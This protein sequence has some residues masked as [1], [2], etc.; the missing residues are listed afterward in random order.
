MVNKL[1][2]GLVSVLGVAFLVCFNACKSNSQDDT[3][4]PIIEQLQKTKGKGILF[5]HQD[6][7]AYGVEWKY[8]SGE[9]DVKRVA[10]DY[11]ALFGWEL[12][13]IELGHDKN[14]DTVPFDAIRNFAIWAHEHG[15]INT[16]SW[17][18]YSPINGVNSW[19]GDSIVV[20][21]ILPGG[22]YHTQFNHQ[23][24]YVADFFLQFK[25]AGGNAIPFIFR[26][27]HEMDGTWFWWG[28]KTCTAKEF[29]ILF[30]YTI[31]YLH[32]KGVENMI[33]AYSPDCKFNT[34]EEYLKWY[35]GDDIISILGMDNYFDFKQPKGEKEALR[36][37]K[38][39]IELSN[40]RGKFSALSETGSENAHDTTFYTKK[41]GA[42]LNDTTVKANL[43][44]V[45]IW[46]NA[47]EQFFFVCPGTP[48]ANDA[49]ELLD[50]PDIL[51]LNEFVKITK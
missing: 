37:L 19:H 17:H 39:V 38:L 12:G 10:E 41:I 1:K 27:W 23:L 20:K 15:G 11:P 30:R 2:L 43:S 42:V 35:P 18:P 6:D 32:K 14:L 50:Q 46:R 36:K 4:N 49:K 44:Y 5:G 29:K 3:T 7:L 47:P 16:F 28:S 21:H 31:E 22:D 33:V 26:P 9:S 8:V 40:E 48:A 45:M 25:D 24:D 13:G 51:L 34:K